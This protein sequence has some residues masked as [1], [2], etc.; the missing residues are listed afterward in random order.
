MLLLSVTL[1][2]G[3]A[4]LLPPLLAGLAPLAAFTAVAGSVIYWHE[5]KKRPT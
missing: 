5:L 3:E 4:G 2:M 1:A